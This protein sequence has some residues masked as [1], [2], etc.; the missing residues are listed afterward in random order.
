M[1][2][3]GRRRTS[4]TPNLTPL[5]DVVFL[6]LVFFM[7]TSHFV[8]EDTIKVDLPQTESGAPLKDQKQVEVVIDDHGRTLIHEHYIEP[9][10]LADTLRRE[11]DGSREKIVRIRGDKA[12][13]LGAAVHVL[14]AAHKAGAKAV[15][16]IT[17]KR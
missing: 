16:I 11:L 2:F 3:E 15:D 14:D 10:A 7:L 13:D 6:L 9:D 1:H 12:A 17:E 4:T 8:K 5:I